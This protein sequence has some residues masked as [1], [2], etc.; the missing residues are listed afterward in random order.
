MRSPAQPIFRAPGTVH[1]GFNCNCV[2][3]KLV[4]CCWSMSTIAHSGFP[5]EFLWGT[6]VSTQAICSLVV[7]YR[8]MS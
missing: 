2:T 3:E 8:M 6:D 4:A 5:L 1:V 7:L